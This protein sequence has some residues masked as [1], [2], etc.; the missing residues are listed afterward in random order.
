MHLHVMRWISPHLHISLYLWIPSSSTPGSTHPWNLGQ[1]F[2]YMLSQ[3]PQGSDFGINQTVP[4]SPVVLLVT[5]VCMY[6][7]Y[8]LSL[9]FSPV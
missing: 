3:I 4:L 8:G 2:Q 6:L 9:L 5:N 1:P 7:S